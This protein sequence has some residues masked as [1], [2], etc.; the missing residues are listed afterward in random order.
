MAQACH[1]M[2]R[3]GMPRDASEA[4]EGA[5]SRGTGNGEG[6]PMGINRVHQEMFHS[7]ESCLA[8]QPAPRGSPLGGSPNS[9]MGVH[10]LHENT[11]WIMLLLM[12]V[13]MVV[14]I[15][16]VQERSLIKNFCM[17]TRARKS[18]NWAG[19][20]SAI[21]FSFPHALPAL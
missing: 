14:L 4:C 8:A 1:Q 13:F 17:Y 3:L 12:M 9:C 6:A 2:A 20:E 16:L 21:K 10:E 7:R 15:K 18:H 19:Q 11:C 5:D